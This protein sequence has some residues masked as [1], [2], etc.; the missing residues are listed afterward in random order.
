MLK[1][2]SKHQIDSIALRQQLLSFALYVEYD[3]HANDG[4]IT[5]NVLVSHE[6]YDIILIYWGGQYKGEIH[7]HEIGGCLMYV[8]EGE[9]TEYRYSSKDN[10]LIARSTLGTGSISHIHNSIALHRIDNKSI[11]G[12]TS[13]HLYKKTK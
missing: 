10:S 1:E 11:N 12:A 7:S 3:W 2:V 5:R 8:H 9:L 6:A 4:E 13:L